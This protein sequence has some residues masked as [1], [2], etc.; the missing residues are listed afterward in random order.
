MKILLLGILLG[1]SLFLR[2]QEGPETKFGK[3]AENV[4]ARSQ[5]SIDTGANAVVLAEIGSTRVKE[6]NN[7]F[8]QLEY[9]EFR[10]VHILR[11]SGYDQAEVEVELYTDGES[12]EKM[13][14]LRAVTYN[15]ENGKITE[16]KLNTKSGVFTENINKHWIRKKFALPNVREGSV[17]EYEFKIISDRRFNIRSWE[18]QGSLPRLWSEYNVAIPQFLDYMLIQQGSRPYFVETNNSRQDSYQLQQSKEVYG[19]KTVSELLDITC[20]VADF[21][22]AMKDIPAFADEAYTS[23][24][25]N[26]ISK[27]SFQLAGYKAPLE[28]RR[29]LNSWPEFTAYYLK[30][31]EYEEQLNSAGDWWPAEIKAALKGA[32]TETDIAKTI[33]N[34]VR[35]NFTCTGGYRGELQ[36]SLRKIIS[37]K[38]G[39]S[40]E[41][42]LLLTAMFRY[43][44]L[45]SDP[46]LLST[47][48]NGFS[49][50]EYPVYGQFNY[51]IARVRADGDDWLVDASRPFLGFGKLPY[52]C[53]NGQARVLN[54]EASLLRLNADQ[55]TESSQSSVF[56]YKENGGRWTGY[57]NYRFGYYESENI[58]KLYQKEGVAGVR[59]ELGSLAGEGFSADSVQLDSISHTELPVFLKY[60]IRNEEEPDGIIYLNPVFTDHFRQ[61][62]FKSEQRQHPVEL[63]YKISQLYTLTME[64]PDGFVVDELPESLRV[65]LNEKGEAIFD[66][67][68]REAGGIITLTYSLEIF[69]TIFKPDEYNTLRDFFGKW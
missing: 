4:L 65:K 32:A 29:I 57:V 48:G 8:F 49:T 2:G 16:T 64:I 20:M 17:I 35:R 47:R 19:G 12:T 6:S 15:L 63:P 41:I 33:Y 39:N 46:V 22:W 68:I 31:E 66:Y 61:N 42:N 5:Y 7:G 52:E 9:R 38:S 28:E 50:E 43:A 30:Q 25:E 14:D 62:P 45:S 36:S 27:L 59:K 40:E 54:K 60:R 10:R 13:T 3:I 69:K 55:L 67:K 24:A 18:F 53:Y 1:A 26:Y 58:R 21:R 51:L 11:K 37:A 23:A 44:G 34:Y 56:I